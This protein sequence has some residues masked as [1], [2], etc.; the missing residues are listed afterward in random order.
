MVCSISKL[1]QS[2]KH[3][4]SLLNLG[5]Q[6]LAL[7]SEDRGVFEAATESCKSMNAFYVNRLKN[8]QVLKKP[9]ISQ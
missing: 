1:H 4:M 9:T 3:C 5:L 7:G 8:H 2:S 6:G